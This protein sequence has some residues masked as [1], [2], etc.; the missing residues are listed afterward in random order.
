M[1]IHLNAGEPPFDDARV[2][3]AINYGI[4]RATI[5]ET[6]LEGAGQLLNSPSGPNIFGYNP[7]IEVYPYDPDKAREL[8]LRRSVSLAQALHRQQRRLSRNPVKQPL[9][10]ATRRPHR[11]ARIGRRNRC[12]GSGHFFLNKPPEAK[13][14]PGV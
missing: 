8:Q 2:R 1:R 10:F 14:F 7:D 11:I 13:K 3:Q 4:D 9:A 12:R 5:L 6:L